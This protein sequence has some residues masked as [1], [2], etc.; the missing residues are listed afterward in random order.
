MTLSVLMAVCF[1]LQTQHRSW[2][3]WAVLA[4]TSPA[5]EPLHRGRIVLSLCSVQAG[6]LRKHGLTRVQ[7]L[8]LSCTSDFSVI[9]AKILS[10]NWLHQSIFKRSEG[11]KFQACAVCLR[12][13]QGRPLAAGKD[14]QPPSAHRPGFLH[15][16]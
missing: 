13:A 16:L 5:A 7:Q 14:A 11:V 2:S 1:S 8:C 3:F 6:S 12:A 9:P 4:I 15:R 10:T